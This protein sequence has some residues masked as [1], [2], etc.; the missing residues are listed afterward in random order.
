MVHA[1]TCGLRDCC[2]DGSAAAAGPSLNGPIE[3]SPRAPARRGSGPATWQVRRRCRRAARDPSSG[4]GTSSPAHT[5]MTRERR[6]RR[7][8]RRPMRSRP[9]T[10]PRKLYCGG[11]NG[12]GQSVAYAS[13]APVASLA[14]D[15]ASHSGD[16]TSTCPAEPSTSART[17]A[18]SATRR[19]ICRCAVLD[20]GLL[21]HRVV[22]GDPP[23]RREL[24]AARRADAPEPAC[25]RPR[26]GPAAGPQ[27]AAGPARRAV[28]TS[29]M[30]SSR[31]TRIPSAR[32]HQASR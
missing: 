21:G 2:V 12:A 24:R 31:N 26:T 6:Q 18:G 20:R 10:T 3:R 14:T 17:Q 5:C 4:G 29:S 25:T 27:P 13:I 23:V 7:A 16:S 30:R 15:S 19:L 22:V 11:V 28:G 9:P 32:R 8:T 1:P